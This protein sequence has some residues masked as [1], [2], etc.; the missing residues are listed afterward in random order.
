M[1]IKR[2]LRYLITVLL[3]F[4]IGFQQCSYASNSANRAPVINAYVAVAGIAAFALVGA[5][6]AN[7]INRNNNDASDPASPSAPSYTISGTV[8]G[9]APG[10]SLLL[11]NNDPDSV[12]VIA[13]KPAFAFSTKI[14]SGMT[15]DV[16]VQTQPPG[17]T[18]T[19][20]NG[21][22]AVGSGDVTDVVVSCVNKPYSISGIV[23]GLVS[24]ESVTLQNNASDDFTVNGS[25]DGRFAFYSFY[26]AYYAVSVSV[27]PAGQTCT[28]T[29]DNGTVGVGGVS[30]VMVE[31]TDNSY[32]IRGTVTGLSSTG[33]VTLQNNAGNDLTVSGNGSG[34]FI[35]PSFYNSPYAVTVSTQPTG[36]TCTVTND[37]GTV[38]VGGVT[39]VAVSC[40]NN[41]Y[42]IG[43]TV[44]S[45]DSGGS[46]ILNNGSDNITVNSNGQ[47]TFPTQETYGSLYSVSIQTQPT[48][49]TCAVTNG[50]GT[51]GSGDV[52]N[53]AVS[54]S[55]IS[56]NIGG[57][58]SGLYSGESVTLSND[59]NS[60]SVNTD[61]SFTFSN[62]IPYESNYNVTVQTQP[63]GQTCAVMNGSGTVGSGDINNI[64]VT[65][66]NNEYTVGGKVT[67]LKGTMTLT[68]N[69][70]EHIIVGNG[71]FT[72]ITKLF[73]QS[74]YS[75]AAST[76]IGQICSIANDDGTIGSGNVNNILISCYAR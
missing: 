4:L 34:T 25:G 56:Y 32:A 68:L 10:A 22:G 16:A 63:L 8:T 26:S 59:G 74:K 41:P 73:Y 19:I 70:S 52:N 27:Q 50:N 5:L 75:V 36:Q 45:L 39:N 9:L 57:T 54:C 64:T 31:C 61:S 69:G 51:V 43:G 23:T 67:G 40:V 35:F 58:V 3:G 66:V 12:I 29:N 2:V 46:L 6:I 17:Q 47:F 44:T 18:C 72:F 20:T 15:Y 24:T 30:N 14:S 11:Q 76:P 7:L 71:D 65:C 38:G 42:S 13:D 55:N 21:S 37:N 49:Q 33:S 53:I 28:V 48:G 62:Q 1:D 60:I